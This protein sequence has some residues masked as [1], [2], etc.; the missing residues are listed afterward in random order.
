[1]KSLDQVEPRIIVDSINTPGDATNTFIISQ[2]GSYYLTGNI[3]GAADKNGISIQASDVTIDLN[4]FALI[5][6]GGTSVR[7]IDVPAD[8]KNISIRN[9]TVRGWTRGGVR[10]DSGRNTLAEKLRLSDNINVGAVG[11]MV[12]LGSLIRDC[13]ANAN[14]TGFKTLDRCQ[15]INCISTENMGNG[16]ESTSHVTIIDCTSSRNRD[17]GILVEHSSSVIRCTATRSATYAGIKAGVGCTVA[18]CTANDNHLYGILVDSG[19][20]VRSCTA[21]ENGNVGIIAIN[22]GCYLTGNTCHAN[23]QD[24]IAVLSGNRV[25]GNSSTSNARFGFDI[26]GERNLVIRNSAKGNGSLPFSFTARVNAMV[27]IVDMSVGGTITPI[28]PW[29]NFIY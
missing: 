6:G 16:F 13:T 2:P 29:A 25:E 24:G 23:L 14:G 7:G 15:V 12:G 10:A 27:P 19:C 22:E 26:I 5:S 20:T 21:K 8:Q 1:M 3:T 9:G 11:I 28:S 4:G 17:N 18:D